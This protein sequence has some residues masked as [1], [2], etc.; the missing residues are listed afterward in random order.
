MMAGFKLEQVAGIRLEY[1]AGF[2]GIRSLRSF[3]L[4]VPGGRRRI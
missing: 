3:C 4:A 1:V 2:A